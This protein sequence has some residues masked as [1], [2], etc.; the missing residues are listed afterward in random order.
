MPLRATLDQ[1]PLLP[2]DLVQSVFAEWPG[3]W[4]FPAHI[5]AMA[6]EV[7]PLL[8][9]LCAQWVVEAFGQLAGDDDACHSNT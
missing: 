9:S 4:P 1:Q 3:A 6:Q 2:L 5:G 7:D 8:E